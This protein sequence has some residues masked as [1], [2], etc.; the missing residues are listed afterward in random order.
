MFLRLLR[1]ADNHLW[2]RASYVMILMP[3]RLYLSAFEILL[4]TF[5]RQ[6][7]F[8]NAVRNVTHT[9]CNIIGSFHNIRQWI[10]VMKFEAD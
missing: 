1:I 8:F 7:A 5:L 2:E 10:A 3:Q 6:N 4:R 9:V